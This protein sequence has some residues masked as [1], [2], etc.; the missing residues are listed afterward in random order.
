MAMSE[1]G[2]ASITSEWVGRRTRRGPPAGRAM[3][4]PTGPGATVVSAHDDRSRD[5]RSAGA[6]RSWGR[7]HRGARRL[8]AGRVAVANSRAGRT[9]RLCGARGDRRLDARGRSPARVERL[10]D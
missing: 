3:L 4:D 9:G 7:V 6:C 5:P 8:D 1:W 10:V 2:T